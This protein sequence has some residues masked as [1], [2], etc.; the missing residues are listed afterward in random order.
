MTP[1]KPT[2]ITLVATTAADLETQQ[3]TPE[4]PLSARTETGAPT[5]N[6]ITQ[7]TSTTLVKPT[8]EDNDFLAKAESVADTS[9]RETTSS[10]NGVESLHTNLLSQMNSATEAVKYSKV[11]SSGFKVNNVSFIL[12]GV[13]AVLL[14]AVLYFA[15]VWRKALQQLRRNKDE[16]YFV[17]KAHRQDSNAR[18]RSNE[19]LD[20]VYSEMAPRPPPRPDELFTAQAEKQTPLRTLS[21]SSETPVKACFDDNRHDYLELI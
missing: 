3:P 1:L 8:A 17:E 4:F 7:T 5:A 18:L 9:A 14:V 16:L 13:I 12:F 15:F 10:K 11:K 6:I 19:L 20:P 21:V 2:S